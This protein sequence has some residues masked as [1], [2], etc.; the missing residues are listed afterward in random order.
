MPHDNRE[1]LMCQ[2][3]KSWIA[4]NEVRQYS[5]HFLACTKKDWGLGDQGHY[6]PWKTGYD[7][8]NLNFPALGIMFIIHILLHQPICQVV[9]LK[10]KKFFKWTTIACF[11]TC[12]YS[13]PAER[14][15][16]VTFCNRQPRHFSVYPSSFSLV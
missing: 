5:V 1:L 11:S 10:K 7:N 14:G 12:S 9:T 16:I 15:R 6:T 2:Y 8:Y 13:Y 3:C 4:Q